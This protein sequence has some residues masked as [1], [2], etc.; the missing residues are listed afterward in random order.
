MK[1]RILLVLCALIINKAVLTAGDCD[2]Q[3]MQE[4]FAP[5]NQICLCEAV[6]NADDALYK[7]CAASSLLDLLS[8][9]DLATFS[10]LEMI[11]QITKNTL[12][13]ETIL[14]N[15][16]SII[17]LKVN[18]LISSTMDNIN[19][20]TIIVS[21]IDALQNLDSNTLLPK[22]NRINSK[23]EEL[24]ITLHSIN[25]ELFAC[26]PIQINA[27]TTISTAGN[28]ILCNNITGNI[29]IAANDVQL[30]MNNYKITNVGGTALTINPNQRITVFNGTVTGTVG[31]GIASGASSVTITDVQARNCTTTG[32]SASTVSKVTIKNCAASDA[33]TGLQLS[34][35]NSSLIKH[36]DFAA[37]STALFF[38]TVTN[39]VVEECTANQSS[40]AGYVLVTSTNNTF[41]D[42]KVATVGSSSVTGNTYGFI[43]T[44][45]SGNVFENCTAQAVQT[46][47]TADGI[48]AVG[49]AL[50]G[51]EN[52]SKIIGCM[53]SNNA[54]NATGQSIPYGILL[55]PVVDSLTTVTQTSFDTSAVRAVAWSPDGRYLAVVGDRSGSG[56]TSDPY[57]TV[58]LYYFDTVLNELTL[59]NTQDHGAT[60]RSV[61]WASDQSFLV[62]GGDQTSNG[63]CT[64]FPVTHRVYSFDPYQQTL[65][66]V[67]HGDYGNTVY[68]VAV[69][70]NRQY[71]A[72]GG[73]L[74]NNVS[75]KV[76][77]Y[78]VCLQQLSLAATSTFHS[79]TVRSVAW[80]LDDTY[81]A[82][83]GDIDTNTQ[84]HNIL[85]FT[86]LPATLTLTASANFGA[87]LNAIAWANEGITNYCYLAVAGATSGG[88]QVAIY[89]FTKSPAALTITTAVANHGATVNSVSWAQNDNYLAIGGASGTDSN[90]HRIYLFSR[91][92][93][94]TL[95]LQTSANASATVNS[96]AFSPDGRMVAIGSNV[97]ADNNEVR[98][99][100]ALTFPQKNIITTNTVYCSNNGSSCPRGVGICGSSIA[101]LITWNLVYNT[102]SSYQFV[103][104]LFDG[105]SD[106]TPSP[107][108]NVFFQSNTPIVDQSN[109]LLTAQ[110]IQ[111]LVSNSSFSSTIDIMLG[112]AR[113][114]ATQVDLPARTILNNSILIAS[115]LD[116]VTELCVATPITAPTTI[117]T[118]GIYC[119]ANAINGTITINQNDVVLDMNGFRI[120]NAAGNGIVINSNKSWI[121][122]K[123]GIIGPVLTDAI[124]INSGCFGITVENV[125]ARESTRGINCTSAHHVTVQNCD[126]S[127]NT[128]GLQTTN[129]YNVMVDNSTFLRNTNAGLSFV[130][131]SSSVVTNC[132]ALDNGQGSLDG[133]YGFVSTNGNA[134]IFENCIAEGTTTSTTNFNTVVAGFALTGTEMCSKIVNCE[135]GNNTAPFS[136]ASSNTSIIIAPTPYGIWLQQN[137]VISNSSSPNAATDPSN[138]LYAMDFSHNCQYFAVGGN[139]AASGNGAVQIYNYSINTLG[140]NSLTRIASVNPGGNSSAI[141]EFINWSPDDNYLAVSLNS[142]TI[143]VYVYRFYPSQSNPNALVQ[144][145]SIN[146]G[147]S[148]VSS[149]NNWSPNGK[150]LAIG[151]STSGF[152]NNLRIYKFDPSN[153]GANSLTLVAQTGTTLETME[154]LNWSPDGQ[155]LAVGVNTGVSGF[156][157]IYSFNPSGSLTQIASISTGLTVRTVQWSPNG[158]YLALGGALTG[159]DLRLYYFDSTTATLTQIASTSPSTSDTELFVSWSPDG[160]Y[161][162]TCGAL[163]GNDLRVYAFNPSL[164]TANILTEIASINP[165]ST[166]DT[167]ETV[168]WSTDGRNI[169]I[170]GTITG[171]NLQVYSAFSFP[172]NNVIKDNITWCNIAGTTAQPYGVGIGGSNVTNLITSNLSYSN[173][174]NLL[175][176]TIPYTQLL[177][178]NGIPSPVQNVSALYNEPIANPDN[179]YQGL[180]CLQDLYVAMNSKLD[181]ILTKTFTGH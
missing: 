87:N 80:S 22:A 83:A 115:L 56:T 86:Q 100:N 116:G 148:V 144:V 8:L 177:D 134:N 59:V 62:I 124:Q 174:F 48:V 143:P 55:T 142:S 166:G 107:L 68:S 122:I 180:V 153:P 119:L 52:C 4:C 101:N 159:N 114:M 92:P 31:V 29:T 120:Q 165:G 26:A 24:D 121:T 35:S 111:T 146:I 6:G 171:N 43:S 50:T 78:N 106:G 112:R 20:N 2:N 127:S 179:I 46:G 10:K 94:A 82:I 70:F 130:T 32:F 58:R 129:S 9:T 85:T 113:D 158:R 25:T 37:N 99:Q 90:T 54:T 163:N 14:E 27:P 51:S 12:P 145:G 38:N 84:T 136:L 154:T 89:Q 64:P 169:A 168:R 34:N 125:E 150:Y 170:A 49:F 95:T 3:V 41:S 5:A 139:L 47:A 135:S 63:P 105:T 91:T 45:G 66:E 151:I 1:N 15:T 108:Q 157:R 103:T 118:S 167:I 33:A 132:I 156:I 36:C 11:D 21:E 76:Y 102:I 155:L 88:N 109:P 141:V 7:L 79:A 138:E 104:N 60:T 176:I 161:L 97:P 137:I 123:N 42:T 128:T 23:A 147:S 133:S 16:Y 152:S 172:S 13:K 61:Q 98:I 18:A 73:A 53:S 96:V 71:L 67:E 117:N 175:F 149:V 162:A 75:T 160:N 65:T 72:V 57:V 30:D 110:Q 28:Y 40:S 39:S 81:L 131:S 69:S 181:L 77:R 44:S 93:T 17:E 140:S 173:L 74:I 19:K 178:A 126:F 164:A